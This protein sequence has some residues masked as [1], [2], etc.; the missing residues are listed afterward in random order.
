M[1][2]TTSVFAISSLVLG[3]VGV[4]ISW[5]PLLGWIFPILAIVFGFISINKIKQNSEL[6]G[7]T[8]AIIG[9]VLGFLGLLIPLLQIVGGL[10]YFQIMKPIAFLPP[11]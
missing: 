9:I 3:I 10:A 1:A 11:G 4:F 8:L 2:K 7:R 5:I 6:K